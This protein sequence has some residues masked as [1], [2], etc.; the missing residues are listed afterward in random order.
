MTGTG[1]IIETLANGGPN[2][3]FPCPNFNDLYVTQRIQIHSDN[4]NEDWLTSS[5]YGF[6]YNEVIGLFLQ[7]HWIAGTAWKYTY[8]ADFPGGSQKYLRG[9]LNFPWCAIEMTTNTIFIQGTE[10]AASMMT[11]GF[12]DQYIITTVGG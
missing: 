11:I 4:L 12:G 7:E 6:S 9:S 1:G 3:L 5:G 8:T 2:P 10:G